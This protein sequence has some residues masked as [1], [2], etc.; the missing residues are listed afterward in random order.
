MAG[1]TAQA[2]HSVSRSLA[3]EL[4]DTLNDMGESAAAL[5]GSGRS[6]ELH[7]TLDKT[8]IS[9]SMRRPTFVLALA[10]RTHCCRI[11]RRLITLQNGTAVYLT[12]L[13]L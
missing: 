11:A 4:A 6:A 12:L 5:D 8:S 10:S 3:S 7:F 9:A 1:S 2:F 13:L